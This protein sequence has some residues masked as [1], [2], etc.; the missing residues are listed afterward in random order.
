MHL[1]SLTISRRRSCDNVTVSLRPDLT[2][3][4]GENNVVNSIHLLA[5]PMSGR[6][7]GAQAPLCSRCR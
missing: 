1:G 7:E 4:V 5:L 6:R 3:L 2:V